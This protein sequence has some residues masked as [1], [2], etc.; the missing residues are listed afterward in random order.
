[1]KMIQGVQRHVLSLYLDSQNYVV[2]SELPIRDNV[3]INSIIDH[4]NLAGSIIMVVTH[5]LN[6]LQ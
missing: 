3:R 4:F 2:T 1:H 6:I 5:L